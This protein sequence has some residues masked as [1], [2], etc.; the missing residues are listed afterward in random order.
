MT[1]NELLGRIV[2][3]L[4]SL[5][6][7]VARISG[8]IRSLAGPT[9]RRQRASKKDWREKAAIEL[10]RAL[11]ETGRVPTA[12]ALVRHIDGEIGICPDISDMAKLIKARLD[13]ILV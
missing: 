3:A 2:E 8:E 5:Q 13:R 12:D 1:D 10:H 4:Q 6:A 11:R 7:D 9:L